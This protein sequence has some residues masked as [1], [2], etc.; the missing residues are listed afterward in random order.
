MAEAAHLVDSTNFRL[1]GFTAHFE[2][3][4]AGACGAKVRVLDNTIQKAGLCVI[5]QAPRS[6]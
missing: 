4:S 5:Y 2:Q 3:S 1:K 6:N